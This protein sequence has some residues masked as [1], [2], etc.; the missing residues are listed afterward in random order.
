MLLDRIKL[1]VLLDASQRHFA[2][3]AGLADPSSSSPSLAWRDA[4]ASAVDTRTR[5]STARALFSAPTA[6]RN[7]HIDA[8]LQNDDAMT[9]LVEHRS[10]IRER[11]NEVAHSHS[12]RRRDYEGLMKRLSD[13]RKVENYVKNGM[14]ALVDLVCTD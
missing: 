8:L 6:Q 14:K 11:G 5:L 10:Q 1:R 7:S 2:I 12:K 13:D 3:A 4:L 9:V